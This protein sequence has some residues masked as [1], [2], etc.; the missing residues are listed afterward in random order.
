MSAQKGH[1]GLRDHYTDSVR[2]FGILELLLDNGEVCGSARGFAF[3]CVVLYEFER[4]RK[5]MLIGIRW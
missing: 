1:E 5:R 3:S 2:D 4:R